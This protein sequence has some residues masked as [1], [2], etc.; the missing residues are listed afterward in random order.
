MGKRLAEAVFPAARRL[1]SCLVLFVS[2][3][4][5]MAAEQPITIMASLAP[6]LTQE[7]VLQ[8]HM[9]R[10]VLSEGF[11]GL[12]TDGGALLPL[13]EIAY[14]LEFPIDVIPSE[15]RAEGWFLQE[16]RDFQLNYARGE[17]MVEGLRQS[18][19][20]RQIEL[21]SDDIYVHSELLSQWFPVKFEIDYARMLVKLDAREPLPFQERM[22]RE[23]KRAGLNNNQFEASHYPQE[24]IP[25][26]FI[27][28]PYV[29]VSM[30]YNLDHNANTNS[31]SSGVDDEQLEQSWGY[32]S[33]LSSDL[34]WM[35]GSLFFSGNEVDGLSDARL[36]LSRKD[37]EGELLWGGITTIDIGDIYTPNIE[38]LGSSGSG[39]GLSFSS[40][41]LN[42]SS[43]FSA[44][45]LRGELP[46]GWE[47]ELYRN[48]TFIDSLTARA[49]GRYEFLDVSL[50]YGMNVLTLKFY[51]PQGQRREETLVIEVGANQLTP[52]DSKFRFAAI[53]PD[54]DLF[55]FDD[56]NS[57]TNIDSDSNQLSLE[58][59]YGL[60]NYLSLAGRAV[61]LPWQGEERLYTG[62]GLRG[63]F[64][65]MS[66]ELDVVNGQDTGS[67][68]QLQL[69]TRLLGLNINGSHAYYND[70]ES[71]D[72]SLNNLS[73][74]ELRLDSQIPES[75]LP[76]MPISLSGTLDR[77]TSG[78]KNLTLENRL[79][80][81]F[82]GVSLTNNLNWSESWGADQST[83]NALSGSLL[84]N[85]PWR[86][87]RFR[88]SLDYAVKPISELQ[89]ARLSADWFLGNN[90]NLNAAINHSLIS[91]STDYSLALNRQFQR[92]SLG[93]SSNYNNDGD[94]FIGTSLSFAFGR[95]PRSGSWYMKPKNIASNGGVSARVFMDENLNGHYDEGEAP[96]VG[97]RLARTSRDKPGTDES[98]ILFLPTYSGFSSADIALDLASL[99]D[100]YLMP[101][102][103]GIS[104][105]LRPGRTLL[106]DFPVS[107]TG[108][109]DGTV[110]LDDG[111][112]SKAVSN[113]VLQLLD[114]KDATVAETKTAFDGFYLFSNVLPGKYLVRPSLE[115][116]KRLK[117][118]AAVGESTIITAEG[119]VLSGI[120]FEL[121]R[122][123][124]QSDI[125]D[126]D[127]IDGQVSE[128]SPEIINTQASVK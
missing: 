74:S 64:F 48:G 29:D 54:Q 90:Y 45:D 2:A 72:V 81:Y 83:T 23:Y 9:G 120:D 85:A 87:L 76:M 46:L 102:N 82:S 35:S 28:W 8:L 89:S 50:L 86:D 96:L 16:N 14:A 61:N 59:E 44:T 91:D 32:S 97:A 11:I 79:S 70:F 62:L 13:S 118:K 88:S 114:Q 112:R 27:D 43:Q 67:A 103:S 22:E 109:I 128:S 100:P 98:G 26:R 7:L 3:C 51:G 116:T 1:G 25:Y 127:K 122:D 123:K 71:E 110:Y 115:Q 80:L 84:M 58:V 108:E 36:S 37:L 34:L 49:D 47:I 18:F 94:A 39:R 19:N 111:E 10:Y 124:E 77:F 119:D 56:N 55:S 38:L 99:E 104:A 75:F 68:A 106:V 101:T 66:S 42:R 5:G 113:V 31:N 52:G 65:G 21:H 53:Q 12:A 30:N 20:P 126:T 117:L 63:S 33:H 125:E 15:G 78:R 69:Q 105:V 73:S 41:P 17:V 4:Q 107:Y 93:L 92:V 95:E 6:N 121:Q 40:F 60:N 57:S 24:E